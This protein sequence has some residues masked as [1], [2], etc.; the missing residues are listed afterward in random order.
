M[1]K[2]NLRLVSTGGPPPEVVVFFYNKKPA[3]KGAIPHAEG[4]NSVFSRKND[5]ERHREALKRG[6]IF[7]AMGKKYSLIHMW[8]C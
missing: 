7:S 6:I 4:T 3:E 5:T 1:D 8:N 2:P